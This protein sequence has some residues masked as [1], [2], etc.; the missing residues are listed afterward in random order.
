MKLHFLCIAVLLLWYT[1]KFALI[2]TCKYAPLFILVPRCKMRSITK[3]WKKVKEAAY[4]VMKNKSLIWQFRGTDYKKLYCY[5]NVFGWKHLSRL[6]YLSFL[7]LH[8]CSL[9][10]FFLF[11][12]L[13]ILNFGVY[14]T[15]SFCSGSRKN[16]GGGTLETNVL[17][18]AASTADVSL[19]MDTS[20][21]SNLLRKLQFWPTRKCWN[22]FTTIQK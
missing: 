1:G 4:K 17:C 22:L 13:G 6:T 16:G 5:L 8:C 19:E 12:D 2:Q 3:P 10:N 9:K 15:T 21:Y 18:P 11:C 14:G 20:N 7:F